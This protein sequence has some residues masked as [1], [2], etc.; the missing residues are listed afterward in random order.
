M[1][2]RPEHRALLTQMFSII[3]KA[4]MPVLNYRASNLVFTE[5]KLRQA[6]TTQNNPVTTL[7][8]FVS[9]IHEHVE[10]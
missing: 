3:M 8:Q 9:Q 4:P 7:R 1:D 5:T 6:G 2:L 10:I